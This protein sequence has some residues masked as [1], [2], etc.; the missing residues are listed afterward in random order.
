MGA[1]YILEW[2]RVSHTQLLNIHVHLLKQ[3]ALEQTYR[4]NFLKFMTA[5]IM[6][7]WGGGRTGMS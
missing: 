5:K 6:F 1:S 3:C 7:V 4:M 2:E